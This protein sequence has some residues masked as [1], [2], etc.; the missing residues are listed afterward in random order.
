MAK[1]YALAVLVSITPL[2]QNFVGVKNADYE[3]A[4]YSFLLHLKPAA[5]PSYF[6]AA[7]SAASTNPATSGWAAHA[8]EYIRKIEYYFKW[9]E[10][11][12]AYVTPNRKNNLRFY[13]TNQGFFVT[14]RTLKAASTIA[15]KKFKQISHKTLPDFKVAF[16]LNKKQFKKGI[17]KT[18][19]NTATY[20][21][22]N[23]TVEYINNDEGMRQNFIIQSAAAQVNNQINISFGINT[24]LTTSLQ[25]NQLRFYHKKTNV[26]NYSGLKVWDAN[27]KPLQASL[28]KIKHKH[29]CITVNT[30]GAAFPITVDPLSASPV[31]SL[32]NAN[33][34]GANFGFSV[35]T[36][37]DVNGDGYSDVIIGAPYFDEPAGTL[38]K[39]RTFVFN[40]SATGIT[41][42]T[43][44]VQTGVNG[45]DNFG[46]SVATAGDVN[47]DGYSDVI[48]G[49]PG[50]DD[51]GN[52]NEGRV[53]IYHGSAAGLGATAASTP[54]DANQSGASLGTS[55]ASAGDVNGDNFS[56]VIIG[57]SG[58]DD[59]GGD[60]GRGYIYYGSAGGIGA[61]PGS[62]IDAF[63]QGGANL[64]SSVASAGDVNGDGFSDVI[65]GANSYDD[66]FANEGRAFVFHGAAGGLSI[67]PNSIL[68]GPNQASAFFGTSVSSAGDVN[69]DG[70]S[71]VIVGADFFDDGSVNEGKAFVY[72][73][74]AAGLGATPLPANTPDDADQASAFFGFSVACAGDINGDGYSDIMVGAPSYH[75]NDAG[76]VFFYYGSVTGLGTTFNVTLDGPN[77]SLAEF[78]TSVAPAGDVNGDGYSDI[79]I[80]AQYFDGVGFN[81]EGGAFTY[82][83][84]ADGLSPVPNSTPDD[85]DQTSAGL[86]IAVAGAGDV[87]GDGYSDVIVGAYL[88]DN[89]VGD[90][91]KALVYH[92]SA[93]GLPATPNSS[94]NGSN[95]FFSYFGVSVAG[96]GDV[97]ADGYSDVVIGANKYDDGGNT[98][99]GAAFV[100]YGSPTGLGATYNSIL[101]DANQANAG[102]GSSVS[103]AG[104]VNKD[105]FS[106]LIVGAPGMTDGGN[107]NE[108][109]AY[110]YHG[111]AT[112]LAAA[113]NSILD[114]AN[115][116]QAKFGV[117]VANAGDVNGD[118]FSDVIVGASGYQDGA[119]VNEG[120]AFVYYGSATGLP[121]LP[122]ATP[123]GA[124]LPNAEF[125]NSVAGAG[126]VN[127]DGYSDVIIGAEKFDNGAST[128][129]GR[130]FVYYGAAAGLPPAASIFLN[131]SAPFALFGK[132]VAGAG[133]INGDGY[134]DV[135]VGSWFFNDAPFNAEGRGYVYYGS[136]T[137]LTNTAGDICNDADQTD[138]YFGFAAASAG[139]VNGDGYSD[140]IWGA[141]GYND[142]ANNDEGRAFLYNGNIATSNKR[143]NLRMYNEDLVTPVNSTNYI[144]NRFGAGLFAKSFI[145]NVKAKMVWETRINYHAYSG[146]PS[147]PITNSVAFTSQ[148]AS[149][150]AL[151]TTGI[152]LKNLID[153]IGGGGIYTKLR[154]RVKYHPATAITGQLYGPWRYVSDI[155]DGNKLGAL[156]VELISFNASW[157]LKGKKAKI[158]FIT[159]KESGINNYTIQKSTDGIN[160]HTIAVLQAQNTSGRQYYNYIDDNAVSNRQYYRLKITGLNGIVQFSNAALLGNNI[161]AQVLIFPNPVVEKLHVI[162]NDNDAAINVQIVNMA[163]QT[164]KKLYNLTPVNQNLILPVQNLPAGLY[165]LHI[166]VGS[167]KQVLQFIK[168]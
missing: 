153:K 68:D 83:G 77:Q 5:V 29:Y 73:G 60:E 114:D 154:A 45:G 37:G 44:S 72:H 109:L 123:D 34:A 82:H 134:S 159:D 88:F 137:G 151:G 135:L 64:G 152:E 80:G 158:D 155:I 42:T 128:D 160:Y 110:V 19:E 81:D 65:V 100:Y 46:Y 113:P 86:G 35:A 120:R 149:F 75:A 74:G 20:T 131:V 132:S 127:G 54:D 92:G 56:D 164:I 62:V 111:S 91:G 107:A 87:N 47:G 129:E 48:I 140:V 8:Q 12:Q 66:G 30:K 57:A 103:C 43:A 143:N 18:F 7:K 104:D 102:F 21:C 24:K 2:F 27:N 148:Q 23:I 166:Q 25:D 142:G 145:G 93:T 165:L 162:L 4:D 3:K 106:D 59:A 40:G 78:G 167:K 22:G 70:Y 36:A 39:G 79:I 31:T 17:W 94:P 126:D 161:D 67:T 53:Y 138:A 133:D 121:A 117:S 97:N 58:Y 141:L 10:G 71:D 16:N 119:N 28:K 32:D 116:A 101:D 139:D 6:N 163:G 99:E 95:Q 122:N 105:G 41:T 49:A 69:G 157:V 76:R 11:L 98:D 108:G 115:I 50:F 84:S 125:G 85:A 90:E 33:Q 1:L 55:V 13:Y 168:Q 136:F 26:L 156:P 150:T 51:G 112:G 124:N 96:A 61:A 144:S 15:S 14:P 52:S 63:N 38:D 130:V 89:G 118:G 9:N 147:I 146:P